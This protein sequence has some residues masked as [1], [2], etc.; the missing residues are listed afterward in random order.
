[1]KAYIL[2]DDVM[3]L[4]CP[5]SYTV[6]YTVS[7]STGNMKASLMSIALVAISFSAGVGLL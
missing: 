1:M 7:D 4:L 3:S 6:L 2:N 5:V